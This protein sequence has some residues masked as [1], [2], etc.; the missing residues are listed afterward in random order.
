MQKTKILICGATGFIGRNCVNHFAAQ[1]NIQVYALYNQKMPYETPDAV[2]KVIWRKGNLLNQD[3]CISALQDIDIVIQAAA[4]TSGA[5]DIV[6]KPYIHVTDNAVMNSLLLRQSM[7][8]EI[9]HFIFLSCTV[10]YQ[11]SENPIKESDWD[12]NNELYRSYFGVGNTKIYIEKMLDFYSRVSQMKTTA[13]RHSNIYGPYDKF[14]LNRSHFLGATISKVMQA[15]ESIT[16]WGTG[17]EKRD[18]LYID[19]LM[20]FIN[21]VIT[22]QTES[23][24]LY[25]CGLGIAHSVKSIVD[26]VVSTSEKQLEINQDLSKPTIKTSLA[27]DCTLAKNDLGWVP[28]VNLSEGIKKTLEWWKEN[29]DPTSLMPF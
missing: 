5:K 19:D 26:L 15:T 4:T 10:M 20:S 12:Q 7:E 28:K 13:I 11:S 3:D 24:K 14:D 23:F 27:L 22:K 18:L 6:N 2:N 17:E 8:Q 29:I 9:K 1:E 16:M 21:L 25:N